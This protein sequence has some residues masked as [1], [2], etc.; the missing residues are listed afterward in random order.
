MSV[1][2]DHRQPGMSEDAWAQAAPWARA[3]EFP[4]DT[5][6][7]IVFA[8]HPDDETLGAG[9]L[10]AMAAERGIPV[11]VVVLTDGEASHPAST[12]RPE[13]RR[14]RR[15]ELLDA[16]A[17][18]APRAAVEFAGFADGGIR[19]AAAEVRRYVQALL[20]RADRTSTTVV[21]PWWGD[22]HRDH[23]VL[24]EIVRDLRTA[25]V[26]VF[27]YPIWLWHWADPTA[28][29][30][31][32]WRVLALDDAARAAKARALHRHLTQIE[33]LS[34]RVGDEAI[35]HPEMLRHFKRPFEIFIEPDPV[36]TREALWFEEKYAHRA[37]PWGVD[38]RW[39]ERRKRDLTAAVLPRPHYERALEL[40]CGTGAFTQILADR[41]GD[42]VAVDASAHALERAQDR[43]SGSTHVHLQQL[44]L[45]AAWPE[46]R[47][48]LIVLSEVAYYWAESDLAAVLGHVD[49]SLD[50]DG[51]FVVCHWRHPILGAPQSGDDV[52]SQIRAHQSLS[53][54]VRHT[55]EDFVLEVFTRP[56]KLQ[57]VAAETGVWP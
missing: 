10:I 4:M 53:S 57:S 16:I 8:A 42:L 56:G 29:D 20:A 39:Y 26:Q 47:F 28:I 31:A 41:A 9:G 55:E 18:L 22:G 49:D 7:L 45:L 33:P 50:E 27:G 6:R 35:I 24:G 38:T 48:D 19:E 37:D 2:F 34:D 21:A 52:H 51:V 46:G 5:E 54:A 44:D 12:T 11:T 17:D 13:L 36:D 40:G 15:H 43:L 14:E 3:S 25:G 32:R 23:R 30:T 1:S